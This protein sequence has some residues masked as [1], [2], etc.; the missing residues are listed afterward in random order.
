MVHSVAYWH[1]MIRNR[2]IRPIPVFNPTNGIYYLEPSSSW[3]G[4]ASTPV[5]PWPATPTPSP[6]MS[7]PPLS[8]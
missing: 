1:K 5:V 2:K 4:Q 3:E 8:M 7:Q 6:L